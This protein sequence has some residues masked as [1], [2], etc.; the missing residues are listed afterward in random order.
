MLELQGVDV[1]IGV[2]P[3]L[4]GIELGVPSGNMCGLIGRNGA[5]KTTLLRSVMGVL[6][7]RAGKITFDTRDLGSEPGHR[8]AHFGIGYMPEDRRLVPD[9]TAEENILV[10]VWATRGGDYQKRLDWIY[11]LIPEIAAFRSRPATELSGGQQKM[12]ALARALIVGTKLLLLDE[13]TEGIAPVLARRFV[14]ILRDLKSEGESVLVAESNDKHLHGLL[15][16]SYV[17]E[18]GSVKL[19]AG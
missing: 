7:A 12:V 19:A 9:L 11:A 5:G 18:R 4:R 1:D 10:P 6:R 16:R 15:D 3:V 2:V 13:P 8:R 14:E 17:I